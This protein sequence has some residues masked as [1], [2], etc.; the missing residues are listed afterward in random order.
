MLPRFW[1]S[2]V[3]TLAQARLMQPGDRAV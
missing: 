2:G 3:R 1:W